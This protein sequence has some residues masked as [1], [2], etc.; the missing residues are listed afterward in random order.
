MVLEPVT[1]TWMRRLIAASPLVFMDH[2]V[3]AQRTWRL[4][5]V[6]RGMAVSAV[7]PVRR[8]MQPS[9]AMTAPATL[10]VFYPKIPRVLIAAAEHAASVLI[11]HTVS[12]V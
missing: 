4:A 7:I 12:I 6:K 10:S 8:V 11:A 5:N 2:A 9:V 3:R 1:V